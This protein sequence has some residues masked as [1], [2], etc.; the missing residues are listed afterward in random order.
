MIEVDIQENV[1]GGY[2][3]LT[4][5]PTR[6]FK[7]EFSTMDGLERHLKYLEFYAVW[8]D[9]EVVKSCQ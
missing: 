3:V 9:I 2:E 4:K 5:L 6:E 8:K 7:K 1:S